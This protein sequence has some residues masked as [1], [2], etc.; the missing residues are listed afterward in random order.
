[1][2]SFYYSFE[3]CKNI[4]IFFIKKTGGSR[5]YFFRH[6]LRGIGKC[7]IRH[8][9][10]IDLEQ[11]NFFFITDI[12]TD[13]PINQRFQAHIICLQRTLKAGYLWFST[14][15][16]LYELLLSQK[17]SSDSV[18]LLA[19]HGYFRRKLW[20]R[21]QQLYFSNNFTE[22]VVFQT[23]F[24][25]WKLGIPGE[26]RKLIKVARNRAG[27]SLKSHSNSRKSKQGPLLSIQIKMQLSVVWK[28]SMQL[29]VVCFIY[30][31]SF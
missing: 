24:G 13:L 10:F 22:I 3:I 25:E 14:V 20:S 23:C 15:F 26:C 31:V 7:W 8:I 2:T 27:N 6:I 5:G 12:I 4:Y 16:R 17:E 21:C 28:T 9:F 1:M 30:L 11:K 18:S 19:P 29:S